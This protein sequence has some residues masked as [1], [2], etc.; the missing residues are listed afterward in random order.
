M[1]LGVQDAKMKKPERRIANKQ[2]KG[3]AAAGTRQGYVHRTGWH[4]TSIVHRTRCRGVE[5]KAS[6]LFE[7]VPEYGVFGG[8]GGLRNTRIT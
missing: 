2:T 6:I 1:K 5:T 4:R 8:S 7:S 3:K